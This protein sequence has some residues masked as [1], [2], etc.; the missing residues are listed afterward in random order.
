ML[1]TVR[2]SRV[3]ICPKNTI[4]IFLKIYYLEVRIEKYLSYLCRGAGMAQWRE[5]SPPT[6]VALVRFPDSMSYV[7]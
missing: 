1:I 4:I 6:N 3:K 2:A 7:G 5:H